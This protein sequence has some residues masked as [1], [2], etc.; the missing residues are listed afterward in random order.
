[1]NFNYYEF[2]EIDKSADKKTIKKAYNRLAMVHH[3]DKNQN[4]KESEELMKKLNE[5]KEVL[6]D[7]SKRNLFDDE[8]N[9]KETSKEPEPVVNNFHTSY[10]PVKYEPIIFLKIALVVVVI[11]TVVYFL[12][13]NEDVAI[14]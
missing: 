1:M 4:S 10:S 8:L 12:F 3:P 9:A 2:L 13:K 7:E 5:A 14:E 6:L 11:A